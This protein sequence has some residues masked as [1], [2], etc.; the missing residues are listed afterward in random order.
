MTRGRVCSLSQLLWPKQWWISLCLK[1]PSPAEI[2]LSRLPSGPDG[3]TQLGLV[4]IKKPLIQGPYQWECPSS[5]CY[6]ANLTQCE[7]R[8]RARDSS[9]LSLLTT[10]CHSV[11][12]VSGALRFVRPWAHCLDFSVRRR[13]EIIQIKSASTYWD[14]QVSG[15]SRASTQP[16]REKK[17]FL[18]CW[19][20]RWN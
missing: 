17:F 19:Q 18:I 6:I 12:D 14:F 2:G 10:P 3:V 9:P 4:Y 11:L 1:W 13:W 15:R 16:C 8:S 20:N 7:D 5:C